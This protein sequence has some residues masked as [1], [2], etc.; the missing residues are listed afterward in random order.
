MLNKE[1]YLYDQISLFEIRNKIETYVVKA[2]QK[3]IPEYGNNH[4][5]R[6]DIEDIYAL[7]LNS[8]PA[9]YV[10]PNS[11]AL[12]SNIN[13]QEVESAVIHAI[14]KVKSNPTDE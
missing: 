1:K 5:D 4:F 2:M 12:D 11:L 14:E 8:L 6:L 7:T 3:L 13:S 9:K 10:Q